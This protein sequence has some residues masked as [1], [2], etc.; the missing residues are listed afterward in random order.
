MKVFFLTHNPFP[1]GMAENKRILCYAKALTLK[2]IESRVVSYK[3]S[4]IENQTKEGVFEGISYQYISKTSTYSNNVTIKKIQEFFDSIQLLL[5]LMRNIKKGDVVYSY[6]QFIFPFIPFGV[7]IK[8][9]KLVKEVCEY[10]FLNDD[11]NWKIKIS[12]FIQ[13]HST[14]RLFDGVIAISD[15]LVSLSKQWFSKNCKII[16]I[17]ILVEYEKYH[18]ADESNTADIRYIFHAGS[19]YESKDGIVGIFK[20]LAEVNKIIKGKLMFI[21]TG[22]LEKSPHAKEIKNIIIE[23][24]LY[25]LIK[26]TGYIDER[27]LNSYLSKASFVIINKYRTLQNRY[28]FS[29]KL[30]EYMAAGKPI[31]ITN[32][33]EAMNWLSNGVD[34]YIIEPESTPLLAKAIEKLYYDKSLC[35]ILGENAQK[36]CLKSFDYREWAEKLSLFFYEL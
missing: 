30:A 18:L 1:K 34:A 8:G 24:N 31:I 35:D 26:F 29:T 22:L 32:V 14:I 21:S 3:R 16:K 6:G 2:G 20:A 12:K 19:L 23:N 27:Q 36:K 33:G 17:P 7:K 9:A 28:C 5:Y 13:L 15:E 4:E 25:D 10:L 11:T